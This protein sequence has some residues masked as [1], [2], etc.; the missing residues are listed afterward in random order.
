[1]TYM[2]SHAPTRKIWPTIIASLALLIAGALSI[3]GINL[4]GMRAGFGF[5]PLI[6]LVVWPRR[7]NRIVSIALIFTVG[8][9]TDWATGGIVGQ[10]ALVFMLIWG[11]LRPE[12]RSSP[13]APIGLFLIW[14]AA[15]T[16]AILVIWL[17]GYFVFRISPDF[18]SLGR[19]A[20]LATVLLPAFML[21]RHGISAQIGDQEDWG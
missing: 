10:S 6:V 2:D 21:L 5:L 8:L 14:L 17:S 7:A 18:A 13:F 15:C 1:M 11:F 12:F 9:F 4:F 3:G 19:Q 16:L 20:I